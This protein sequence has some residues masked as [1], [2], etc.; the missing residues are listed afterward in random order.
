MAD[1]AQHVFAFLAD[2]GQARRADP[3]LAQAG[4]LLRELDVLDELGMHIELEK[5]REPAVEG[6]GFLAP[7]RLYQFPEVLV[8]AWE[9]DAGACDPTVDAK[10]GGF[11]D[12]VV[13]ADEEGIAVADD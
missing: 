6:E 12:E 13:D 10:H 7:V 5:R 3:F 4:F 9:G 8:L 2:E 11:E 1:D